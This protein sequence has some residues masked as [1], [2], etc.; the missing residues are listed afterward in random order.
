MGG[1]TGTCMSEGSGGIDNDGRKDS[2]GWQ[3]GPE[4][5]ILVSKSSSLGLNPDS[6]INSHL[7]VSQVG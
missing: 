6:A 7:G 5:R 1:N 4:L 3:D 2:G